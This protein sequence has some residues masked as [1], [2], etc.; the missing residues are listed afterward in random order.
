MSLAIRAEAETSLLAQWQQSSARYG[1][2]ISS[3][4][5]EVTPTNPPSAIAFT[6][7]E[8]WSALPS[9]KISES[10]AHSC[11]SSF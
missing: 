6:Q 8:S 4:R 2:Y 9:L 5:A 7:D 3:H 11:E 1:T 10:T